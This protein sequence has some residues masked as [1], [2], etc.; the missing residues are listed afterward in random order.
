MQHERKLQLVSKIKVI[1]GFPNNFPSL[2]CYFHKRVFHR[3]KILKE[4]CRT[5]FNLDLSICL[6]SVSAR[7]VYDFFPEKKQNI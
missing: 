4:I 1:P 7:I 3:I 5:M 2:N 6:I